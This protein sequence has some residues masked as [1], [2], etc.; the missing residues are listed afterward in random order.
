MTASL[1]VLC[2]L[3]D[4]R[5]WFAAV[6]FTFGLLFLGGEVEKRLQERRLVSE[7]QSTQSAENNV[8]N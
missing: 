3:G 1:G 7:K 8:D 5:L 2:G 6:V 4:W